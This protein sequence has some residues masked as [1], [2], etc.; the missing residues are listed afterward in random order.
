M[1]ELHRG[2]PLRSTLVPVHSRYL[3]DNHSQYPEVLLQP[4]NVE[5]SRHHGLDCCLKEYRKYI[6]MCLPAAAERQV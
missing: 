5:S 2:K 3:L 4:G 6:L 1:E